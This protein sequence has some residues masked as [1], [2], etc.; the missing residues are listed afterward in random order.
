MQ[1]NDTASL[2]DIENLFKSRQDVA[3]LRALIGK[4]TYL[5]EKC[6]EV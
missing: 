1:F 4:G 6:K 5:A 3:A 2:M